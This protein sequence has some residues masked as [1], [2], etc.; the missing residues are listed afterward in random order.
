MLDCLE[1]SAWKI[2]EVMQSLSRCPHASRQTGTNNL[3][4]VCMSIETKLGLIS[5][6]LNSN[7]EADLDLGDRQE[8]LDLL[9]ILEEMC[10]VSTVVYLSLSMCKANFAEISHDSGH[11]LPLL[12]RQNKVPSLD[13]EPSWMGTAKMLFV[14][15]FNL[16]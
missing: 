16:T 5:I 3:C 11:Q 4:R 10:L 14:A 13:S 12:R 9:R 7:P 8:V 2:S 1:A 15:A 6:G